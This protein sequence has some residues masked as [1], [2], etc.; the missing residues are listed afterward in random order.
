MWEI[1]LIVGVVCGIIAALIASSK[2]RNVVGW[3]FVGFFIG[4]IGVIIIACL[5]N[6]K[7]QRAKEQSSARERHRLREQLRQERL[8]NEA[9]RRHSAGRL[10][11]HDGALNMD[12]RSQT[13]LPANESALRQLAGAVDPV[14][15][16]E[17]PPVSAP[18]PPPSSGMQWY[19]ENAGQ[20]V[21]PVSE[22]AIRGLL[23]NRTITPDTLVW[24]ENF[25]DWK[26]VREIPTFRPPENP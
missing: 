16:P 2:G 21:G 1:Q 5:S 7:Q 13:A 10:D 8:K 4:L 25:V 11:A 12:T 22:L 6:L 26:P 23:N 3:F 9:F 17:A 14:L 24:A 18:P 19:Y 20:A 15:P